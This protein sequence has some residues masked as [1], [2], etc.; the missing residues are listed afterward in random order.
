MCTDQ[1]TANTLSTKTDDDEQTFIPL[2][3]DNRYEISTTEPWNFRRI[4]KTSCL[5]Q[6]IS[7][8]GY[9]QVG[10]GQSQNVHRL[11][12]LQYIQNDDVEVNTVVHHKDGNKLNNSLTNL[13]WTTPC[14]NRK[15][16]KSKLK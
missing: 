6:Q 10:V 16:A 3:Y 9:L 8:S 4:G 1:D 13:E 15:L 14:R 2:V 12:A 7:N 11:V 5:R